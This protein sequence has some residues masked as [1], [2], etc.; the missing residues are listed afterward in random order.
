M[1]VDIELEVLKPVPMLKVL[2]IVPP[3]FNLTNLSTV[4]PLYDVKLPPTNIFPSDCKCM[5]LTYENRV[6]LLKPVP[7]L[8]VLS[9]VPPVFNLII[10]LLS[11]P[12]YDVKS[13]P[14]NILPSG[15]NIV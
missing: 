7:M 3:V 13:P 2:S 9:I 14:T 5:V 12:L 10:L 8:K 11:T 1:I 15:C 4:T 6:L